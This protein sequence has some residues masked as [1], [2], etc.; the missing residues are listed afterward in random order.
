MQLRHAFTQAI[1][2]LSA[3]GVET[4]RLDAQVLLAHLLGRDQTWLLAHDDEELSPEEAAAYE[5][6]IVRRASHEP[7]AYLTGHRAFFGLDFQVDDRVL[8]PR[9]ETELL[10]E[11][12]LAVA[13]QR[14][15]PLSVADIGTG[16]GAIA[17]SLAVH[18]PDLTI[19]AVDTS[20]D[21]LAVAQANASA[22][23]PD[24]A[25]PI[26][27]LH[28]DL[29]APLPAPVDI[30]AA[31]LPYVAAGDRATL[32]PTVRD[33]EPSAALFSGPD[34]LDHIRRLLAAAPGHLRPGGV[35]LLEMG[36]E[37]G[38]AIADLATDLLPGS[39]TE[40]RPDLAGHDRLAIIHTHHLESAMPKPY[41]LIS[42]DLDGTILNPEQDEAVSPDVRQAIADAQAAG[43][44]VTIATGRP[45]D[46]VR[47]VIERWGLNITSPVV[48]TQ[49]AVIGDPV[50]GAV[51]AEL[52]MPLA[53]A[54]AVAA[55][56]DGADGAD[57]VVMFYF[58]EEDGAS[59]YVQNWEKW[60][61]EIYNIWFSDQRVIRPE[62]S[63]LFA[64]EDARRPLKFIVTNN[65]P[66]QD[67]DITPMLQARFGESLHISR[68]HPSLVEGTALGVDK[69]EGVRRMLEMA[70]LDPARVMAIGDND[71]DLPMFEAVGFPVAMGHAAAH[72]QS[73]ARWVAPDLAS[74]G[75]AVAIRRWVLGM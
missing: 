60:G 53:A 24:A 61:P 47:G 8:I 55:W 50:S 51:L 65:T 13:A 37:Q 42:L 22:L 59:L 49:G 4:P 10:V 11:A 29:L 70:G 35:I 28:G 34:G 23:L 7:V 38:A 73:A 40:I 41:D 62:L 67:E 26:N 75:V 69:G 48:T 12:V 17:V 21:A 1:R 9:P 16:S 57:E 20:P 36:R 56:A 27:F 52:D 39:H 6:L 71:N 44:A 54:R 2:T 14:P 63:P 64:G 74:D 31:N 5:K 19:Y 46:Y 45:F 3:A 32:A 72:V 33:H 18:G 15:G 66:P 30:I 68:T 43:V 25:R 58:L